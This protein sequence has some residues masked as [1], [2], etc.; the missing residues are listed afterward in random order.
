MELNAQNIVYTNS[1]Y[2]DVLD[3]FFDE[4]KKFGIEKNKYII[5]SDIEFDNQTKILNYQNKDKY[6]TRLKN[7]LEQIKSEII[8][9]QH[10]DMFLYNFPKIDKINTYI[11]FLKNTKYSFI[12]LSKTGNCNLQQIKETNSL[13][14]IDNESN[15]FFAVQPT[16]WKTKDMIKFLENGLHMSIWE[17]ETNSSFLAKKSGIHGLLHFENEEKR[18][19]HY[20]SSIWPYIATAIVKGKWNFIEY[21]KELIK[22]EKINKNKRIKL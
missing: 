22:I 13:Y 1:E 19:G 18:G 10:E 12:R 17:L 16:I 4:Q 9:Y 15:D 8:L 7:C 3:I 20:D 5:F 14:E 21:S 11:D 2:F 6:A